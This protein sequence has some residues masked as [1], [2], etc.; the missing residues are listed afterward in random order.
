[1]HNPVKKTIK[2]LITKF[3]IFFCLNQDD[4]LLWRGNDMKAWGFGGLDKTHS[5]DVDRL[6]STW[7]WCN[8]KTSFI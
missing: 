1:M 2:P 6:L 7:S 3:L 4:M 5:Y 8:S